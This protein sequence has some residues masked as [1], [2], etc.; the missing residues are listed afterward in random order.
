MATGICYTQSGNVK[1][2][3]ASCLRDIPNTI[4]IYNVDPDIKCTHY[5]SIIPYPPPPG[6]PEVQGFTEGTAHWTSKISY[7]DIEESLIPYIPT[8]SYTPPKGYILS[9]K[10]IYTYTYNCAYLFYPKPYNIIYGDKVRTI[11]NEESMFIISKDFEF[12][13]SLNY[14]G[15]ITKISA[16]NNIVINGILCEYSK[17]NY[18]STFLFDEYNNQFNLDINI[19]LSELT[20]L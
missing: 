12:K 13:Y 16:S 18:L 6:Y 5:F 19:V 2:Y 17:N 7:E 3:E 10:G 20:P 9:D 4:E 11:E 15:I 1:R 14:T 8:P